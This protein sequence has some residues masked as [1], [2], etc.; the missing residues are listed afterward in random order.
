MTVNG[1]KKKEVNKVKLNPNDDD[2][3]DISHDNLSENF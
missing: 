2:D 3:D 1:E